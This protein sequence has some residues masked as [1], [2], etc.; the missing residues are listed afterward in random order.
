MGACQPVLTVE[1]EAQNFNE[2]WRLPCW[3]AF[4]PCANR[5]NGWGPGAGRGGSRDAHA[6]RPARLARLARPA[7]LAHRT[8][9][10]R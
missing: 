1:V 3:I 7:R 5:L 9:R 8:A 2:N 4:L 6:T 10:P